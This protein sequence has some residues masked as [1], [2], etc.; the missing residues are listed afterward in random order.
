MRT[1]RSAG[2]AQA[3]GPPPWVA[4]H[5]PAA[6]APGSAAAAPQRPQVPRLGSNSAVTMGGGGGKGELSVLE[7]RWG[8][9][10]SIPQN[11]LPPPPPSSVLKA[12]DLSHSHCKVLSCVH[13]PQSPPICPLPHNCPPQPTLPPPPTSAPPPT[14]LPP[15]HQSSHT[16]PPSSPPRVLYPKAANQI[17]NNRG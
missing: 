11:C 17:I 6:P 5:P 4:G 7:G 9:D 13:P 14:A 10:T 12:T 16:S 8:G 15:E 2:G 3:L 1:K